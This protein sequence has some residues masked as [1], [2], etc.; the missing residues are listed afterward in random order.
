MYAFR[1]L[2][3]SNELYRRRWRHRRLKCAVGGGRSGN[4]LSRVDPS[5]CVS[6]FIG[7]RRPPPAARAALLP[8]VR[9]HPTSYAFNKLSLIGI[10][11]IYSPYDYFHFVVRFSILQNRIHY[12]R[13]QQSKYFVPTWHVTYWTVLPKGAPAN[14]A[15]DRRPFYQRMLDLKE[16]YGPIFRISFARRSIA[17]VSDA[18]LLK[19]LFL[20]M[21]DAIAGCMNV[22]MIDFMNPL[23]YGTLCFAFYKIWMYNLQDNLMYN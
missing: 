19:T 16:R 13:V 20:D 10:D 18:R 22:A 2:K 21:G 14:F 11:C 7:W 3:E 9:T 23:K 12:I 6:A 15:P 8:A 1:R 17:I 5:G 4:T